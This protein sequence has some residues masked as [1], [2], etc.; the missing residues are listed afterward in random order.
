MYINPPPFAADTNVSWFSGAWEIEAEEEEEDEARC[1]T[2]FL[3]RKGAAKA[4][5][6]FSLSLA[7]SNFCAR[8]CCLK[9]YFSGDAKSRQV[10]ADEFMRTGFFTNAVEGGRLLARIE[11]KNN[12]YLNQDDFCKFLHQLAKNNSFNEQQFA[13][14]R[15]F[16]HTLGGA[17][18]AFVSTTWTLLFLFIA[19][20]LFF[21]KL[22]SKEDT[23][24]LNSL[25]K[26]CLRIPEHEEYNVELVEIKGTFLSNPCFEGSLLIS[27][28]ILW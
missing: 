18:L 25:H 10:V 19:F 28:N 9:A 17:R 26:R 11:F 1:T 2:F 5:R 3:S 23:L 13:I 21:F 20:N 8:T 14:I 16:V 4:T 7:F 12:G 24:Y 27:E 6:A 22:S 15:D